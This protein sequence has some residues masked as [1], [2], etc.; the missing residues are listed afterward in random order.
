MTVLVVADHHRK[1][2]DEWIELFRA[3]LRPKSAVG[4]WHA[5]STIPTGCK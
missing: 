1:S 2:F 4:G 5:E 3:T